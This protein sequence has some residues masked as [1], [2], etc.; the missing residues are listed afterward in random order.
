M[1]GLWDLRRKSLPVCGWASTTNRFRWAKRKRAHVPHSPSGSN[2]CKERLPERP[3]WISQTSF[4]LRRKPASITSKW[5]RWIPL[6]PKTSPPP[7]KKNRPPSLRRT[8]LTQEHQTLRLAKLKHRASQSE[9]MQLRLLYHDGE[10][11]TLHGG[12]FFPE[13]IPATG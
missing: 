9:F 3:R 10:R 5:T 13:G 12:Q 1:P 4:H 6:P 8:V 2:L 11:R 7:P